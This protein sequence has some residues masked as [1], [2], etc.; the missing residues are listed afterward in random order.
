MKKLLALVLAVVMM[1]SL[2][3]CGGGGAGG[4][5]SG[6]GSGANV[7]VEE[8]YGG[9]LNVPLAKVTSLDPARATGT[10]NYVW[11]RLIYE[12]PLTR[13]AEGNI[14][15]NVCNFELS[16]DRLTLKLWVREGVKFHD[17][18][19]VEIDDVIASVQRGVHSSPRKYV[20][21]YIESVTKND[22]GSAT[23]KFKEYNE[24]TMYY[25]AFVNPMIG[26]MPKEICE[27]YTYENG[28]SIKDVEDAIGTGPYKIVA[29]EPSVQLDLVRFEDYVPVP[30]G[31]TGSA[32][33]KLAYMDSITVKAPAES[34]TIA[35]SL[36]NG[37]IDLAEA[38]TEDLRPQVYAAGVTSFIKPFNT[39]ITVNFNTVGSNNATANNP[40]L[41]KAII[42]AINIP[43]LVMFAHPDGTYTLGGGPV[44][45]PI[46]ADED[47]DKPDYMGE[48]KKEVVEKYLKAA[49]YNGE[50]IEMACGSNLTFATLIEAY[51]KEYDIN[52]KI[53]AMEQASYNDYVANHNNPWDIKVGYVTLGN[54]PTLM[55]DALINADYQGAEKN[56]L[57]KEMSTLFAGSDEYMAKWDELVDV[58]V[59]DCAVVVFA[60]SGLNWFV[61]PDLNFDYEGRD[62]CLWNA[63]W[64]NP[65]DH[66][67]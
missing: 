36:V 19:D 17:G 11:T 50:V 1:L 55:S 38:V 13:D 47:F 64:S 14:C 62:V 23:F 46:Y 58:I 43:E 67:K 9:H 4:S 29:L 34:N 42:A 2:A 21:D 30:E 15:P 26:V 22:D 12:A 48:D 32:A 3:A 8:R 16:D 24:K 41:R 51:L 39:S 57:L 52:I 49:N 44:I 10:W 18:T 20:R 53:N 63:Y 7:P 45:D 25:I 65:A 60:Q 31:H 33:P 6:S 35:M 59:E 37:K 66:L 28:K 56:A 27:K 40:N 5:G 61:A 54:S